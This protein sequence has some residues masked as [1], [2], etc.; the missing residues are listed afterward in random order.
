M[1]GVPK[2]DLEYLTQCNAVRT[3]GSATAREAS[4]SNE[5]VALPL[6]QLCFDYGLS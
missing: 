1:L 4:D 5:S 3:S 6:F 2:K